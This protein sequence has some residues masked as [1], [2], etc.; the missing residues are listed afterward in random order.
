MCHVYVENLNLTNTHVYIKNDT[1]AI[2]LHLNLE[3]GVNRSNWLTTNGYTYSLGE[4]SQLCGVNSLSG[5]KPSC[6]EKPA[7]L[8]VTSNAG[9]KAVSC[10]DNAN[11]D[12]LIISGNSLPAAW[13][14]MDEGRI[15]P[16]N[17]SIRG[18]LWSSAICNQGNLKIT[19]EDNGG[20]AYTTQARQYW[21]FADNG[22]IGKRIVRGIRGSGF[23]IFK[24]W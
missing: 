12:D 13:I 2:V 10:P 17:A 9:N 5:N 1:R 19:T 11:N 22:G 8:V 14:S 24:R 15:R 23:D 7:Q 18:V 4:K 20:T 16:R 6:N 3:E 21:D